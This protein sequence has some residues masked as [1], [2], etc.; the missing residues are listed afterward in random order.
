M[1]LSLLLIN[2]GL[3]AVT[4]VLGEQVSAN[5]QYDPVYGG[6]TQ[7]ATPQS[8]PVKITR[9]GIGR[10]PTK[11]DY[12]EGAVT[13]DFQDNVAGQRAMRTRSATGVSPAVSHFVFG[14]LNPMVEFEGSDKVHYTVGDMYVTVDN[15]T[16]IVQ[17]QYAVTDR[18]QSTRALL[19]SD[20]TVS[21]QFGYDTLGKPTENDQACT[22]SDCGPAHSYPYHFQGH[23]YLAWD[24]SKEGYQPGLTD[25]NDRLYSHDQ[26]LRFMHTDL[27]G[28]SISPYTAY[29]NAP[30]SFVDLNGLTKSFFELLKEL[31]GSEWIFIA[32]M[33]SQPT[34]AKLRVNL[35]HSYLNVR[36]IFLERPYKGNKES[37]KAHA[38]LR[39]DYENTGSLISFRIESISVM[40]V[41]FN[42]LV[43]SGMEK[44]E[45]EEKVIE[46]AVRYL[47]IPAVR[48][49][50]KRLDSNHVRAVAKFVKRQELDDTFLYKHT[51]QSN[52]PIR[53]FGGERFSTYNSELLKESKEGNGPRMVLTGRAHIYANPEGRVERLTA[54]R[55]YP[56]DR[57][58]QDNF[59]NSFQ[60]LDKFGGYGLN[61]R[62][63]RTDT[64][65]RQES[66]VDPRYFHRV[67]TY[68]TPMRGYVVDV[69]ERNV[70]WAKRNP[71]LYGPLTKP[72]PSR[73]YEHGYRRFREF[74]TLDNSSSDKL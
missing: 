31:Q 21:A 47:G 39:H 11:L 29:G 27:A 23:Q 46:A 30:V 45:V 58:A 55:I 68:E 65:G 9:N 26:G 14:G 1:R 36:K 16:N 22:D 48:I 12:N 60:S 51:I 37:N 4:M 5:W 54:K 62:N 41:N 33:H 43:P 67:D 8:Q 28:A 18:L 72:S 2:A 38:S 44:S 66:P 3:V 70:D 35:L 19:D 52:T 57:T 17:T 13:Y 40:G 25:N 56:G 24:D 10:H 61:L 49:I 53:Y 34:Y 7:Y 32:D 20:T 64:K 74:P 6:L 15:N 42:R 71:K 50:T 59:L 73:K 63:T 69:Y